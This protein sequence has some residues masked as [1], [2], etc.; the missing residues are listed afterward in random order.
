MVV[1]LL[2]VFIVVV[3]P[4]NS[5]NIPAIFTIEKPIGKLFPF[6]NTGI[7]YSRTLN[8]QYDNES[9]FDQDYHIPTKERRSINNFYTRFGGGLK[10]Q[11]SNNQVQL[12][13]DYNLGLNN[14]RKIVEPDPNQMVAIFYPDEDFRLNYFTVT[15]GFIPS[16]HKKSSNT[17][18]NM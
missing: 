16:I 5:L 13:I 14:Q 6:I 8:V 4:L 18:N 9:S 3:W 15:I 10:I 17:G 12:R 11:W 1:V 2:P 7:V